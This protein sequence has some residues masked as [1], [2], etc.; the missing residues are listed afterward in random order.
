MVKLKPDSTTDFLALIL[1]YGYMAL[2]AE[3]G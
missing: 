3:A 2:W 1:H